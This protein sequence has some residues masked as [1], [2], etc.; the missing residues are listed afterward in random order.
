MSDLRSFVGVFFA[1][2]GLRG[3]CSSNSNYEPEFVKN[4]QLKR[5]KLGLVKRQTRKFE[6]NSWYLLKGIY[7]WLKNTMVWKMR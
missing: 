5:N 6:N 7:D 2:L 4:Q 3:I 1:F